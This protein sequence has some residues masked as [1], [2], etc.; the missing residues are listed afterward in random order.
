MWW[1]SNNSLIDTHIDFLPK[2]KQSNLRFYL[3]FK[4]MHTFI[5]LFLDAVRKVLIK[6]ALINADYLKL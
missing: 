2:Q 4:S 5:D 1:K 6:L 3:I